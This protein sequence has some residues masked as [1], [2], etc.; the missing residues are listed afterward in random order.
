MHELSLTRN[1]VSMVSGAA[2]GRKVARVKLEIGELSGVMAEAIAFCFDAVAA[3]TE[4]EG[5]TLD[6][7]RVAGRGRCRACG[8][9]FG[10]PHLP[11]SC[12][13]GSF[14]VAVI[15][16]GDIK[17]RTMEVEEAA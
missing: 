5:A 14:D 17:I 11:A 3:G 1:L 16:G 12:A 13:C 8:R 9:E 10:M 4:L 15:D 6:I 2:H 7:H